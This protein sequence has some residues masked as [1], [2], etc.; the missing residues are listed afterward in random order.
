[1]GTCNCWLSKHQLLVLRA[2]VVVVV[3][4]AAALFCALSPGQEIQFVVL[5]AL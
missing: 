5:A 4:A 1:M 3:V 2:V